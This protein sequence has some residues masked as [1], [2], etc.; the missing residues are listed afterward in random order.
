MTVIR[1]DRHRVYPTSEQ[2]LILRQNLG[3][4]RF[5][6]NYCL[7]YAETLHENGEKYPGYYGPDGFA[8]QITK[9]KQNPE[10]EWLKGAD[11]TA[12]QNAAKAADRAYRNMFARRA[13]KPRFKS[14]HNNRQTYTSTNNGNTIRF[15]NGKFIRLP[16]VG[17]L[18]FRGHIRNHERIKFSRVANLMHS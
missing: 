1:R 8:A 5:V 6:Y 4:A 11:N 12:L 10:Y 9:L 2:E 18:C 17:S 14:K 3:S 15:E 7:D 13:D 16:K